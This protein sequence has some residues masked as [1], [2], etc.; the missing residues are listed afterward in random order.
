MIGPSIQARITSGAKVT[1]KW[2]ND[3][4]VDNRKI[5]G[6]LIEIENGMIIV[7]IGCN[8]RSAPSID[9]T[10]PQGG[11]PSVRISNHYLIFRSNHIE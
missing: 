10:G 7:G 3:V 11:R 5:C 6:V 1:L 2:P 8:V 9:R 4:L